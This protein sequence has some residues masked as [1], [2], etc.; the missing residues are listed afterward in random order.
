MKQNLKFT[1]M[2][3]LRFLKHNSLTKLLDDGCTR[4]LRAPN[5]DTVKVVI[6]KKKTNLPRKVRKDK[7][8]HRIKLDAN[9]AIWGNEVPF[10]LDNGNGIELVLPHDRLIKG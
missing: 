2:E 1:F 3:R 6:T 7:G 4:V 5:V 8:T 10:L 9:N